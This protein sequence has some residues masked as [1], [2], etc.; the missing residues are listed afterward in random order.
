MLNLPL[1]WFSP[2]ERAILRFKE[3]HVACK[4]FCARLKLDYKSH[5]RSGL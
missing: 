4:R 2:P 1:M 5:D 3:F